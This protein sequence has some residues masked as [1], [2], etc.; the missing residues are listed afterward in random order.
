ME[1]DD[2]AV[3]HE[4]PVGRGEALALHRALDP[5]LQL[6]GLQAR[7]EEA[8]RGAFKQAF[9]EPLD[10]GERRHGRSR[11]YQRVLRTPSR[12]LPDRDNRRSDGVPTVEGRLKPCAIL[13]NRSSGSGCPNVVRAVSG[14]R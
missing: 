4:R 5:S 9:E 14:D 11:L 1:V 3:R 13:S 10:G 7:P 12:S 2:E 8:C 6:D